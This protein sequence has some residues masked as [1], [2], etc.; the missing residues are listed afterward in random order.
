MGKP[1]STEKIEWREVKAPTASPI[2]FFCALGQICNVTGISGQGKSCEGRGDLVVVG[3]EKRR[4]DWGLC[5]YVYIYI[6]AYVYR[7]NYMLID[8][9][10]LYTY[11]ADI[12]GMDMTLFWSQMARKAAFEHL[13]DL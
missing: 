6:C 7:Y 1:P 8:V 3:W 11:Y 13:S 2:S 4:F 10:R 9:D 12:R 5:M